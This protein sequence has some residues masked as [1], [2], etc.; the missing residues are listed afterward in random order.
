MSPQK[1]P[2]QKEFSSS[3]HPFSVDNLVFFGTT[4]S[5]SRLSSS[6]DSN[7]LKLMEAQAMIASSKFS[8]DR[9]LVNAMLLCLHLTGFKWP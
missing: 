5:P 8:L 6:K 2:V 7:Y 1:G 4:T 9:T 3:N